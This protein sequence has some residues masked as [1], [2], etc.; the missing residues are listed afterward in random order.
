MSYAEVTVVVDGAEQE[1]SI[2]NDPD[3]M[4]SYIERIE[5]EAVADG[6]PTEVYVIEHPHDMDDEE[7]ACV[8]YLTDHRPR[9]SW[10]V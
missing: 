6:L 1:L 5:S 3:Q 9:W 8:Q 10:N 2:I 4:I 7:C